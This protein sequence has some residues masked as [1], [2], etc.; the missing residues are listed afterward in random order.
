AMID[1][2]SVICAHLIDHHVANNR[3]YIAD[4][5]RVGVTLPAVFVSVSTFSGNVCDGFYEVLLTVNCIDRTEYAAFN[6]AREVQILL[7]GFGGNGI[8]DIT[9]ISTIPLRTPETAPVTHTYVM[10][11]RVLFQ[12][13]EEK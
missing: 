11:F 7:D 1:F 4:N 12:Y 8:D 3:V 9:H 5:T 10:T 6:L 13:L 2:Q